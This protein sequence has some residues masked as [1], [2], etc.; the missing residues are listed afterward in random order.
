MNDEYSQ[1]YQIIIIGFMQ[2]GGYNEHIIRILRRYMGVFPAWITWN[3]WIFHVSQVFKA[4][5]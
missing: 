2:K 5:S 4:N 1:S 3:W